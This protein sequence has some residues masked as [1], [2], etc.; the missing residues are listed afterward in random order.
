MTEQ[1]N[2]YKKRLIIIQHG[3][4]YLLPFKETAK[5]A[6]LNSMTSLSNRCDSETFQLCIKYKIEITDF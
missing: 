2:E 1:N 4:L 6:Y 5:S 3:N